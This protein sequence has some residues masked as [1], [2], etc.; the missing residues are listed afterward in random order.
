MILKSLITSLVKLA[1]GSNSFLVSTHYNSV[2]F[3]I[4][5][6]LRYLISMDFGPTVDV[7]LE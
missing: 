6:G 2:Q 3:V 7:N 5:D 4:L 1:F